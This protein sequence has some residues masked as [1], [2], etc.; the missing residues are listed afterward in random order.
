MA[1]GAVPVGGNALLVTGGLGTG[2][3]SV[4]VDIAASLDH[5]DETY[6]LIDL[7]YL[8]WAKPAA[9]ADVTVHDLLVMNLTPVV[10]GFRT[11][12]INR[13]ILPRLLLTRA[14]ADRVREALA[15]A[16]VT[17]VTIVELTSSP[18]VALDR[19]RLRDRGATLEEHE[20]LAGTLVPEDGIAEIQFQTDELKIS[21]VS[22]L[23]L[24]YWL[25][26][27]QPRTSN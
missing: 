1:S 5:T 8:C 2:K 10:R 6:A 3:T 25:S 7:D 19:L 13:F 4:A 15:E 12:G 24:D 20:R 26:R 18:E 22:R 16:G 11:A 27:V 14:E 17:S 9:E 23:I 21:E